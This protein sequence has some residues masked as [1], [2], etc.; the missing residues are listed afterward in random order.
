MAEGY[1]AH[2]NLPIASAL[3][4]RGE[5]WWGRNMSDF[6][7]GAGQSVTLSKS[8][9]VR[10]RGGWGE[11]KVRLNRYWSLAPGFTTDNPV[12]ADLAVGSRT[13]NRA[14]YIGNRFT[15][16]GKMEI[17]LDYLRWR[18]DYFGPLPGFD[19]RINIFFQY[20]F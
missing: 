7:G 9:I 16:G 19:N 15:P 2:L 13:R 10:G 6:R 3:T 1:N 14:F 20:G 17:G 18:T 11:L 4:F 12:K 5:G 8:S